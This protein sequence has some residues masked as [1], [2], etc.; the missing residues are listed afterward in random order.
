M[1]KFS[2]NSKFEFKISTYINT[3]NKWAE[4][5]ELKICGLSKQRLKMT[6]G[7]IALFSSGL[8]GRTAQNS[9]FP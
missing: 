5:A 7:E 9:H 6:A 2:I 3:K 8:G 4:T 1:L